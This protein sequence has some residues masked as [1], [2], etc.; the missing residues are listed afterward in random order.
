MS[1]CVAAVHFKERRGM[2]A[3]QSGVKKNK[4]WGFTL[5]EVL[6]VV[7]IIAILAGI[8]LIAINPS[9]QL[10]DTR[11]A[12][13]S[14]DVTTILDAVYQYSVDS[15][16]GIP[17]TITASATEICVTTGSPCTTG[18]LIDLGVVT[19]NAKYLVGMP[20][21]P[22]CVTVCAVNGT[23]YKIMKDANS[24]VT[25]SAPFAESGKSISVTR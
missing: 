23:G 12:Q 11:N 16:A 10:G 5:L 3:K 9:K 2:V 14:N 24:R 7:A 1:S 21:D 19:S 13:R 6:L 8:V 25:V 15:N 22:Q 20:Q 4:Q 18:G 17:S